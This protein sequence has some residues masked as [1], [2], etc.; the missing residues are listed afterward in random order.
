MHSHDDRFDRWLAYAPWLAGALVVLCFIALFIRLAGNSKSAAAPSDETASRAVEPKAS[1]PQPPAPVLQSP[2]S[3]PQPP[4]SILQPPAPRLQPPTQTPNSKSSVTVSTGLVAN[5]TTAARVSRAAS[6]PPRL[7]S[8]SPSKSNASDNRV[9]RFENR[10]PQFDGRGHTSFFGLEASGRRFV[11]VLDRSGSMGQPANRP[12]ESA[13][14]ELITSL[15]RLD[16]VHQFFVI[17]YNQEPAVFNP[18]G[19]GRQLIFADEL[20]KRTARQF[21]DSIQA[22]GG[23]RHYEA[24][25]KAIALRPD[26]IFLLT[27]GEPK[28]DLSPDELARLKRMNDGLAQIHVV[29][30]APAPYDTNSLVRLAAE[31]RGE[32]V[33][34]N[35]REIASGA[36]MP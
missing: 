11:Y 6:A 12:L 2:S 3:S 35:I 21:I 5:Q 22:I 29:Q 18:G 31:N 9:A 17:F 30:F 4:A 10:P 36:A 24:L 26:V 20:N 13:K 28:D 1:I 32:H 14:D 25:A 19:G 27:D 23:T 7:P 8:P 16:S 15:S 33:Y 34:K